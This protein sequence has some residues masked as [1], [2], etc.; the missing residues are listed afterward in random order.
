MTV[1]LLLLTPPM[2]GV[3]DIGDLQREALELGSDPVAA[4]FGPSPYLAPASAAS[5]MRAP[6]SIPVSE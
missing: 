2:L 4:R 5:S 1:P 3:V 6:A